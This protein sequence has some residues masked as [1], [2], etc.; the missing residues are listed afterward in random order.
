MKSTP[1]NR[2]LQARCVSLF[3]AIAFAIVPLYALGHIHHV[4]D[5]TA[6]DSASGSHQPGSFCL[7]CRLAHDRAVKETSAEVPTRLALAGSAESPLAFWPD[8]G[9]AGPLTSRGPPSFS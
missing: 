6:I 4:T 3:A 1:G 5:E 8:R 7:I 9:S 2:T